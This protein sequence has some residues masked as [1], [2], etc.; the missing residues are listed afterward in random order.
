MSN[1]KII[2]ITLDNYLSSIP[3][4]A[5]EPVLIRNLSD[6]ASLY[7]DGENVLKQGD[8]ELYRFWT[9]EPA[10]N[11]PGELSF[12]VTE[13]YS[14]TI[15][16][17]Y[18]MTHGHY[19]KGA[20]AEIYMGVSG[21]GILLLQSQEGELK[22]IEFSEGNLTYIP[23]GWGHRMINTGESTL[24]FIAVWPTG[25]EHDYEIMHSNDFKV[26]VFRSENGL[27]FEEDES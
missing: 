5:T 22:K 1:S 23:S 24:T 11:Q 8:E 10:P 25:I 3:S 20:G 7:K 27:V 26:K 16:D 15:G 18:F 6:M 4:N 13:L 14:G 19:H 21:T 2:P 12:G 17:E 9:I